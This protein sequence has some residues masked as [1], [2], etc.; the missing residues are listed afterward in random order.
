MP[1]TELTKNIRKAC[2]GLIYI[3][4]IDAEV[5]LFEGPVAD[6]VTPASIGVSADAS[7]T[8]E[9]NFEEFC[10]RLATVREWHNEA[11]TERAKKFQKLFQ[12]MQENLRQ[13]KMYRVGSTRLDIY[14]A[15]LD[16]TDRVIGILTQ[17]VET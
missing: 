13:I 7:E 17:A 12:L 16:D 2:D 5:K 14:V 9:G 4:E 8:E 15:G 3:S 1:E 11:Q 6:A 10:K